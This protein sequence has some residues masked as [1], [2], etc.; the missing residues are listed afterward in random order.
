MSS[1]EN[2]IQIN[3][4]ADRAFE[5]WNNR[6]EHDDVDDQHSGSRPRLRRAG[7]ERIS[8]RRVAWSTIEG[9]EHAGVVTF[10]HLDDDT[11]QVELQMDFVMGQ[12]LTDQHRSRTSEQPAWSDCRNVCPAR[13]TA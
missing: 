9:T 8:G 12:L 1:V 7:A 6:K 3:T 5:L 2:T 10:R 11:C 4:D 13:V